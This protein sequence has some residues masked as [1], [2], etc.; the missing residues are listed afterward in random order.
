MNAD[1]R[2]KCVKEVCERSTIANDAQSGCNG[3][4]VGR[5]V[6]GVAPTL[7]EV[8]IPP[9]DSVQF[10]PARFQICESPLSMVILRDSVQFMPA[11]GSNKMRSAAH[12]TFNNLCNEMGFNGIQWDS[13]QFMPARG[14][15][16]LRCS[17]R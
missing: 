4:C 5:C 17:T 1:E 8:G 11:R 10:M 12:D 16:R 7:P 3:R 15:F 14:P 6:A 13:V 2:A 9:D